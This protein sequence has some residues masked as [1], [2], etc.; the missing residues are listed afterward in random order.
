MTWEGFCMRPKAPVAKKPPVGHKASSG[1]RLKGEKP[2]IEFGPTGDVKIA[3]AGPG[4]LAI[5]G[6]VSLKGLMALSG[7]VTIGGVPLETYI[8]RII[9]EELEKLGK[10]PSKPAGTPPKKPAGTPP[11]KPAGS[12]LPKKLAG[13]LCPKYDGKR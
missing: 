8:T 5:H 12:T 6:A 2:C 13:L 4:T 1:L 9:A 3:R 10:K 7:K 11:K